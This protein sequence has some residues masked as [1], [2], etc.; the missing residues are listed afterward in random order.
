[1]ASNL[2][3]SL[4]TLHFSLKMT[5]F[6]PTNQII[7]E[8]GNEQSFQYQ[9]EGLDLEFF[10]TQSNNVDYLWK[11]CIEHGMRHVMEHC[12]NNLIHFLLVYK[13]KA[14]TL[15]PN[16]HQFHSQLFEHL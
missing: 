8:Y 4:F 7:G 16:N 9:K 11:C 6:L 14:V 15:H 5:T 13:K 10:D 1:M 2:D 12:H 3:F